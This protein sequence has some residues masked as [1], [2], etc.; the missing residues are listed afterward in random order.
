MYP[1][2]FKPCSNLTFQLLTKQFS[3]TDQAFSKSELS[4]KE[5]TDLPPG[6]TQIKVLTYPQI[7]H[8]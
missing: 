4:K 1:P 7:F 3:T 5:S 2:I 6:F 8:V